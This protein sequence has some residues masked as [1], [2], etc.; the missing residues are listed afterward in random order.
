MFA[1]AIMLIAVTV[2]GACSNSAKSA[3]EAAAQTASSQVLSSEAQE[4]SG[5]DSCSCIRRF[6]H[7]FKSLRN[8]F[9][10]TSTEVKVTDGMGNAITLDGPAKKVIVFVPSALEI[11]NGLDAMDRVIGVDSWSAENKEPLAEGLEGFGDINSLN[12]EKIAAAAP[13]IIIGL[14]GWAETDIQKLTDLGIKVYIVDANTV[15]EVYTEI[16]NMG[17]ILGLNDAAS[18]KMSE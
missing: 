17:K 9:G 11:I 8:R 7:I 3:G 4:N 13:D 5:N 14:V 6:S 12:M 18:L 2:L 1:I 16:T 15:S 10:E